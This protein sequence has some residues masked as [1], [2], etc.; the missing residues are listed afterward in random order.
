MGNWYAAY[1]LNAARV[2]MIWDDKLS[3]KVDQVK[4]DRIT[5]AVLSDGRC[6]NQTKHRSAIRLNGLFHVGS[7]YTSHRE[8]LTCPKHTNGCF[9]CYNLVNQELF[10][11]FAAMQSVLHHLLQSFCILFNNLKVKRAGH[12]PFSNK[13]RIQWFHTLLMQFDCYWCFIINLLT[14]FRVVLKN[15]TGTNNCLLLHHL[16]ILFLGEG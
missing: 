15:V 14:R 10:N 16:V 5:R 13:K 1:L 3:P 2:L 8:L 11:C 12:S 6:L 4:L 7:G 9:V